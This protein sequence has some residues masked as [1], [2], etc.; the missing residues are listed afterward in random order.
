MTSRVRHSHTC[1]SRGAI[2]G[3]VGGATTSCGAEWAWSRGT[4]VITLRSQP[5]I[6]T[7][8]LRC[9]HLAVRHSVS[10]DNL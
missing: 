2:A 7:R 5:I 3:D 6:H 10:A 8:F 1:Q 4:R 9:R